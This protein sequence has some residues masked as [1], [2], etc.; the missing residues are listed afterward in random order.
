[1]IDK[2]K[3]IS[4]EILTDRNS[5]TPIIQQRFDIMKKAIDGIGG[6]RK[7]KEIIGGLTYEK[8]MHTYLWKVI[9]TY[10][11]SKTGKCVHCDSKVN[12]QTHHLSYKHLGTEIYH[13]EDLTVYCDKCHVIASILQRLNYDKYKIWETEYLKPTTIKQILEMDKINEVVQT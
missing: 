3:Y 13:L 2:L 11:I 4:V 9:T 8:Y 5:K 12:L 1:M 10:C 7:L 6:E